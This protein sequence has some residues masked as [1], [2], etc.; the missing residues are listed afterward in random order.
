[1]KKNRKKNKH[2]IR[3][4][5]VLILTVFIMANTLAWFIYV[6]RVDNSVNV[7]VKAWNVTFQSGDTVIS[8]NVDVD[9]D[10]LYPG[11]PDYSYQ[12]TAY[13]KSE[14]TAQLNYQILEVRLLD[15]EYKSIEYKEELG[16][17]I[18]PTDLTSKQIENM[19]I[20]ELPFVIIIGVTDEEVEEQNGQSIFSISARWPYEGKS[21]EADTTWGINAS[22]YKDTHPDVSSITLKIKITMTQSET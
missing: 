10:S 8:N 12:I 3:T 22:N 1:M 5:R 11:M 7:R 17:E 9:I 20:N 15:T 18:L 4:L 2:L 16:E 14:V 13:N 21:D 6:T 19:L